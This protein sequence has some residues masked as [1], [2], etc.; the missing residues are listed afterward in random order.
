[1]DQK[2][3]RKSRCHWNSKVLKRI[4]LTK[5]LPKKRLQLVKE[6]QSFAYGSFV[7]N[8]I[9]WFPLL[10]KQE[11]EIDLK[12]SMEVTLQTLESQGDCKTRGFWNWRRSQRFKIIRTFSRFNIDSKD[13]EKLY[14]EVVLFSQEGLQ[15]I[16][17]FHEE[18]DTYA[19]EI[20]DRVL[21]LC[22][23]NTSK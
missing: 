5:S 22:R 1:M 10:N 4:D 21:S 12:K 23:I 17:I 16:M 20:S 18:G 2:Y 8:F 14:Y 6:M 7:D 3:V 15:Q 9:W 11:S 19:N 13:S